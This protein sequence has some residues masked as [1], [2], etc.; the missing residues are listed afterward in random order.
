MITLQSVLDSPQLPTLPQVAVRLLEISKDP[1]S[2]V[3]DIMKAIKN[4][5]AIS[6]K[7]IKAANSSFFG[8]S[9]TIASVEGAVPLLGSN[10][11]TSL[12]L[13]FSLVGS[14][15]ASKR[16]ADES[17]FQDYWTRSVLQ[18]ATAEVID[19]K[20][21]KGTECE[22]FLA[23]LLVDVGYLAMLKTAPNE[24]IALIEEANQE[25]VS[26]DIVETYRLGFSHVQVGE[27][28]LKSWGLPTS[29]IDALVY[30]HAAP[31]AVLGCAERPHFNI[32]KSI[33][34]AVAVADYLLS[35]QPGIDLPK[36]REVA[37][38]LL[39][40]DQ[41]R[42]DDLLTEAHQRAGQA[43][44]LLATGGKSIP[45]PADILAAANAALSDIVMQQ[46]AAVAVASAESKV[47][48]DENE[49]L[50]SNNLELRKQAENDALTNVFNR[51]ACDEYLRSTVSR[52]RSQKESLGLF[53]I[54]VDRFKAIN[55]RFGHDVGDLVLRDVA[56]AI[57]S[58]MRKSNFVARY[59]GEEFV[60]IVTDITRDVAEAIA[61]R[62]R[63][64]V[65]GQE[66][67]IEGEAIQVTA[68]IGVCLAEGADLASC[69][70]EDIVKVADAAMYDCKKSGRNRVLVQSLAPSMPPETVATS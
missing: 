58:V 26:P 52:C 41:Q 65:E 18:A 7:V 55:D 11:V 61:E 37:E 46:H 50:R 59:G 34:V 47:V 62:I 2:G 56:K 10:V 21:G 15:R 23:G 16:G 66:I 42:L 43:Q 4:D 19:K 3:A 45:H 38:T 5:P 12:A 63:I 33:R 57:L 28:L 40:L 68:S 70:P 44:D 49:K 17:F 53:F 31:E 30:H 20:H 51:R 14:N 67:C 25:Q 9:S 27:E 24:C 6:A 29:L 64:A 22:S 69:S 35:S 39:Q 13:S 54:D 36:M 48:A 60:V 32:I 8:I 1:N